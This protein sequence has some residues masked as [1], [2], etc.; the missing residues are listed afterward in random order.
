MTKASPGTTVRCDPKRQRLLEAAMTTF[1]RYGFRKTSM[2]EVAQAAQ[3]SRQGLYLHF[4]TK[5][6]LFSAAA[7]HALD[8]SLVAASDALARGTT[9]EEKLV[10]AFDA[11]IGRYAGALGGDVADLHEACEHLVGDFVRERNEAFLG[12]ITKAVRASGLSAAHKEAD[13]GA[14]ELAETLHAVAYG[15]KHQANSRDEFGRRFGVAVRAL[16]IPL[17]K[18]R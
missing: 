8:S 1:L 3:I 15:L 5:E 7:R 14:R 16:C 13:I 10:G 2:E 4:P 11:W 18:S 6:E 9:I 12:L 17:G